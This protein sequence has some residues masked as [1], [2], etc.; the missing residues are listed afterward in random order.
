[1]SATARLFQSLLLAK[2]RDFEA[3]KPQARNAGF[4]SL[5]MDVKS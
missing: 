5:A 4:P 1:M 3:G 2:P